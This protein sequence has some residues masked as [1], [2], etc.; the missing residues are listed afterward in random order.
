MLQ[1]YYMS[2]G[3]KKQQRSLYEKSSEFIYSRFTNRNDKNKK[4][5]CKQM[6]S[7]SYIII[8]TLKSKVLKLTLHTTQEMF[9]NV[10]SCNYLI[11]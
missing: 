7:S 8:N 1:K 3:L 6:F 9:K 2:T 5:L 10:I 11:M 4:Y